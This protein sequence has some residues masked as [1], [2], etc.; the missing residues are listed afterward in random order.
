MDLVYFHNN[1][2]L[3]ASAIYSK[4]ATD[5]GFGCSLHEQRSE[6]DLQH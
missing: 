5:G 6:K 1:V 2:S 4:G 3:A